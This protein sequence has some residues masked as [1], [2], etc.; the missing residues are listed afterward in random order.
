MAI[1]AGITLKEFLSILY[2][3]MMHILPLGVTASKDNLVKR[4]LSFYENF[5]DTG[6]YKSLFTRRFHVY[7]T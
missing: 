7:F 5:L 1:Y 4:A 2:T 3:R 6:D